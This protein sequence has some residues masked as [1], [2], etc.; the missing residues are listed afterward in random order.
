MVIATKSN[1]ITRKLS[2]GARSFS[3]IERD[4]KF[5]ETITG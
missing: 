1:I 2:I 3:N 4:L 5:I